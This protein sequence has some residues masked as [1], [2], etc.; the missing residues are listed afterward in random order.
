MGRNLEI[1]L[2]ELFGNFR[3]EPSKTLK[4]EKHPERTVE[5]KVDPDYIEAVVKKETKGKTTEEK[6]KIVE[7]ANELTREQRILKLNKQMEVAA[8][9]KKL[10]DIDL[11][12]EKMINEFVAFLKEGHYEVPDGTKP[13]ISN[14]I[15]WAINMALD[16]LQ[17]TKDKTIGSKKGKK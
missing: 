6:Q 14:V 1:E 12:N 17:L 7:K 4:N 9:I 2:E 15:N 16:G 3:K 13:T 5:I 8:R 11:E 10:V